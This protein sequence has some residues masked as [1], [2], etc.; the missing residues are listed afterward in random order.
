MT[1]WIERCLAQEEDAHPAQRTV[2]HRALVTATIATLWL[3]IVAAVFQQV[4]FKNG[5]IN[6]DDL[7]YRNQAAALRHGDLTLSAATHS[8]FFLPYLTGIHDGR[9]VFTHQPLWPAFIAVFDLIGAPIGFALAVSAALCAIATVALLR[10]VFTDRITTTVATVL[11]VLSPILMIQS[12]T[13]LGYLPTLT[14]GVA[15]T[16]VVLRSVRL[17]SS[18]WALAAGLLAGLTIFNRPFDAAL[19]LLPVAIYC[20][21]KL[22]EPGMR[23]LVGWSM[24]GI[25]APLVLLFLYNQTVMGSILRFPYSVHPQ[26]TIGFGSRA[27]F[28]PRGFAFGPAQAFSGLGRNSYQVLRWSVGGG[29]GLL[30]A[31]VGFAANRSNRTVWIL[32]SWVISFPLGYFF[33]WT[34][35]NVANFGLVGTLGPFYYLPSLI[36]LAMLAGAGLVAIARWKFGMAIVA[37]VAMAGLS[38]LTLRSAIV[39]NHAVERSLAAQQSV[40][41]RAPPSPRIELTQAAFRNDPY[42]RYQNPPSLQGP[43]LY[44]LNLGLAKDV[45]LLSLYPQAVPYEVRSIKA[46]DGLFKPANQTLQRLSVVKD[47][48]MSLTLTF[49]PPE[50]ESHFP[51][52]AFATT[53]WT[54][55]GSAAVSTSSVNGVYS[56]TWVLTP[57]GVSMD[58][59]SIPIPV[60]RTFVLRVG[61]WEGGNGAIGHGS[62]EYRYGMRSDGSS[63]VTMVVPGE[64]WRGYVFPLERTAQ[65]EED[66]TGVASVKV[67]VG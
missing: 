63:E 54:G 28:G 1:M 40:V 61:F 7:D 56:A 5:S 58:H 21:L 8:P 2:A 47:K 26:D 57:S 48:R 9:V 52:S 44:A 37:T 60:D 10:E 24:V 42:V 49:R 64:P 12:G 41:H 59:K 29:A 43:V 15:A 32:A 55:I 13:L 34:T 51:I 33:F 23:T 17:R 35:W 45:E 11:V 25:A 66:L 30:L 65:A 62:Y 36:A 14:L 22:R 20:L 67:R 4:L 3:A 31:V 27:S 6:L 19:F 38:A 46:R 18:W 50:L 53:A 16:S 39:A